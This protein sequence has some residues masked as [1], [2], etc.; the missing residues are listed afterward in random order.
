MRQCSFVNIQDL[1][2]KNKIYLTIHSTLNIDLFLIS[3][4]LILPMKGEKSTISGPQLQGFLIQKQRLVKLLVSDEI[5]CDRELLIEAAVSHH[6]VFD[7]SITS[8]FLSSSHLSDYS[9]GRR[10]QRKRK[11][12]HTRSISCMF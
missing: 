8:S 12:T 7:L 9:K 4:E 6:H 10:R 11:Q 3:S 2:S 5:S 1:F